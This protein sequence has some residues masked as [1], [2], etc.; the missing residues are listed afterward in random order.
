MF[1]ILDKAKTLLLKRNI[2]TSGRLRSEELFVHRDSKDNNPQTP[3]DFSEANLKRLAAVIQNYPEGAQRSALSAALDIAQRQ[4]GWLPISAMHK[5]AELLSVPRMRVY[6]WATFYTMIKRKFRGKFNIKVCV[7]TP[8]M[9]RGS[10]CI[11]QVVEEET[12]CTVGNVSKDGLFGVDIV[13]CQGACVNAPVVVVDDDYYEDVTIADVQNIIQCLKS[14]G[15]PQWGP[16]SGRFASEP[17]SGPTTLLT[18]P[19]QPGF[20]IQEAL[21]TPSCNPGNPCAPSTK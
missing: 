4:I 14:G 17:I 20:G 2:S 11:L 8:C 1:K 18:P 16:L 9:L 7:T 6:E 3:F 5:I 10:D 19:P 21:L 12:C 13:Q 15:I